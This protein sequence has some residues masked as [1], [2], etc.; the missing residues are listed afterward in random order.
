LVNDDPHP[1]SSEVPCT[2]YITTELG[3]AAAVGLTAT[4]LPVPIF[5]QEY[6]SAPVAVNTI[7]LPEQAVAVAGETVR[8]GNA[9]TETLC[10]AVLEQP[11]NAEVPVTV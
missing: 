5:V 10:T 11:V 3:V 9:F 2:E 4:E 1:V 6:V 8:L 7:L